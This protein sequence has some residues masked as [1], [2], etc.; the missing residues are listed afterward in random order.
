M[1]VSRLHEKVNSD[2]QVF[3]RW[4][5][6]RETHHKVQGSPLDWVQHR[7]YWVQW[8]GL[9]TVEEALH[10]EEHCDGTVESHMTNKLV[11]IQHV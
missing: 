6:G 11:K 3:M 8:A 5:T 2:P 10:T 9:S 4:Q 7:R 1:Q